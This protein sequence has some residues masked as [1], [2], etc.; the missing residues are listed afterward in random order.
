MSEHFEEVQ[1]IKDLLGK[2]LT[3][4]KNEEIEKNANQITELAF[5]WVRHKLE[6]HSKAMKKAKEEDLEPK[7][8]ELP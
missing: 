8:R 4:L 2:K 6:Q 1:K 7:T 5:F 3:H